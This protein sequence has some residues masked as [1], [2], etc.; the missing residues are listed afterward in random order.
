MAKLLLDCTQGA[1]KSGFAQAA[2][3]MAAQTDVHVPC[4]IEVPVTL[5]VEHGEHG[6][7]HTAA[8]HDHAHVH[9]EHGEHHSVAEVRAV[10]EGAPVSAEAKRHAHGVYDLIAEAEAKAHGVD[11]AEVHFHEVGAH[12]AVGYILSACE[13]MAHLPFASIEATPVCTGFGFVDCAHGTLPI[14]APATANILDG[15]PVFAG[16]VEGE[17]TTPTGAAL[18]VHFADAFCNVD[19]AM[20]DSGAP[21]DMQSLYAGDAD[22]VMRTGVALR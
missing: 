5:G 21:A 22:A 17:L 6:P 18:V 8:H 14:P 11:I 10:I 3:A 2:C 12:G 7:E 13:A 15:V 16:N 4:P 20:L 19:P 9:A 1:T